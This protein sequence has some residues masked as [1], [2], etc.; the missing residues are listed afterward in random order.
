MGSSGCVE[1]K[2][3]TDLRPDVDSASITGFVYWYARV[4]WYQHACASP[5][6]FIAL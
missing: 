2:V 1:L 4:L 6:R 5:S 3:A